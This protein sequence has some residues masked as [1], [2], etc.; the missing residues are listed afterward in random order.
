MRITLL[1]CGRVGIEGR[2]SGEGGGSGSLLS[3]ERKA[4]M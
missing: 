2:D 1:L 4:T 3:A